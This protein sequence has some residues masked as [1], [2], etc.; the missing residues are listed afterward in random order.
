V[1][2]RTLAMQLVHDEKASIEFVSLALSC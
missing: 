1:A 2:I